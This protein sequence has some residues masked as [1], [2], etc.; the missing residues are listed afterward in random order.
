MALAIDVDDCYR[1]FG[2]MVLRRCRHILHSEEQAV[3]AMQD[4][5]VQLVRNQ[6]TIED[7]GMSS[8]LYRMATNTSL[9]LIR[10][11]KRRPEDA[12]SEL[13]SRIASA[14]T[15]TGGLALARVMLDRI[16]AKEQDSTR[17]M[18][19][20]HLLDG[21]TLEEVA[22]EFGLSVSGVRKRLRTLKANVAE[23]EGV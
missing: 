22:Q 7:R 23:L 19:V 9:N 18:A 10:S 14:P 4:V 5:F 12:D 1:R 17:A 6:S 20:M 16:F 15:A 11:R 13:V 3:E 8:L 21:F 2:P